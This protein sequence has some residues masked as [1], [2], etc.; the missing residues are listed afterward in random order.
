M[1]IALRIGD[2]VRTDS[3]EL[4]KIV[5]LNTSSKTADVQIEEDG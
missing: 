2:R 4:G 3:D 1:A 5:S